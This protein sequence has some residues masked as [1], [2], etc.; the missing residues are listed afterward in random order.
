MGTRDAKGNYHPKATGFALTDFGLIC[1]AAHVLKEGILWGNRLGQDSLVELEPVL[2]QVTYELEATSTGIKKQMD[3]DLA[4]C[5]VLNGQTECEPLSLAQVD[6]VP[7]GTEVFCLGYL[8][9]GFK[10]SAFDEVE[11]S[12]DFLSVGHIGA[13]FNIRMGGK[14]VASMFGLDLTCGQGMSGAP[15]CLKENGAVIGIVSGGEG[16]DVVTS[17]KSGQWGKTHVPVGM[18]SAPSTHNLQR[19]IDEFGDRFRV[20]QNTEKEKE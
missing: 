7:T 9:A 4:I 3:W 2:P 1:T 6:L 13:S 10:W 5:R 8:K 17:D 18:T 11:V 16:P 19:W 12:S 20:S 15:V 14:V